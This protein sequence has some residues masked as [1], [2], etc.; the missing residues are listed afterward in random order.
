MD[1]LGTQSEAL[2]Y[3]R[4]TC[5]S[6]EAAR[7]RQAMHLSCADVARDVGVDTATISRWE[8]GERRPMGQAAVRFAG[9]LHKWSHR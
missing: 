5:L 9:M 3:V 4:S 8:R 2:S 6:G 1:D 7:L